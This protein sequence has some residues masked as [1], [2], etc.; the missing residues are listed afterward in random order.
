VFKIKIECRNVGCEKIAKFLDRFR[1]NF[2]FGYKVWLQENKVFAA[3]MLESVSDLN[4][5]MRRLRYMHTT[6]KFHQVLKV[7]VCRTK[8]QSRY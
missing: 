5:L 1:K 6:F 2:P 7:H 3:F 8:D 4:D